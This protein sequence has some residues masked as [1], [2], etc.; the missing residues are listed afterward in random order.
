LNERLP[1]WNESQ[2]MRLTRTSF[3][4]ALALGSF[5]SVGNW[6]KAQSNALAS[7]NRSETSNT[8]FA[9]NLVA[10]SPVINLAALETRESF[11]EVAREPGDKKGSLTLGDLQSLAITSN[12]SMQ[13][14]AALIQAARG[15]AYQVGLQPNPD[16]GID[17]QQL[18]SNGRAEQYG[19]AFGQQIV[20]SEKLELNRAIEL[21]EVDRLSQQYA[22][23]R[24]RV[25]TDVHLA[26]IR[27][28]RAQRQIDVARELLSIDNKA[29][30][31]AKQLLEA[32]E[33]ARTDVLR[34]EI[35]VENAQVLL[36]DAELRHMA[37]WRELQ[38]VTGQFDLAAATLAGDLFAEPREFDFDSSLLALQ[39]Q[40]PEIAAL[41]ATIERA[42]CALR[43]QQ[44]EPR[45]DVNV[46]G[47]LNWRDNG[48]DGGVDAGLAVTVPL[49]VWDK[50]Q[51]AIQEA[52]YQ[53]VSAN[54]E[55]ERMRLTLASRLA[56]VFER[57]NSARQRVESY[58]QRIIPRAQ[59]TVDLVRETYELGEVNFDSLLQTQRTYTQTRLAY[60]D[61][62]EQLRLAEA[63]I[64][65]LLLS[66]SLK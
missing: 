30:M 2:L 7:T 26:Y 1:L 27:A 56:P 43:R 8:Q 29:L 15:R 59:E 58:Q 21:H 14:A 60:V 42:R 13:S 50:N 45:P 5:C 31:V 39:S 17:F 20:R 3:L 33:V 66:G 38:A 37:A 55:L 10:E 63:E 47:L 16:V 9:E 44:I 4:T 22:A 41:V 24:W 52:R 62:V 54:Q 57:L 12:P 65:G 35:E 23:A 51:G 32:K 61:S 6:T 25:L 64:E 48:I 49:P 28:L 36:R 19:V 18:F 46:N 40:S 11:G 53:L 34:A